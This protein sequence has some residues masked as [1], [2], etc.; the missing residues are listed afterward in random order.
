MT[1]SS[2]PKID[3]LERE[4][5]ELCEQI[6]SGEG[7]AMRLH[8]LATALHAKIA[9]EELRGEWNMH[10]LV[11]EAV[12]SG[13][14]P[15]PTPSLPPP[16]PGPFGS[17]DFT[18]PPSQRPKG[19]RTNPTYPYQFPPT[20]SL[21]RRPLRDENGGEMPE[22]PVS[23]TVGGNVNDDGSIFILMVG[24]G[25]RG[26]LASVLMREDPTKTTRSEYYEEIGRHIVHASVHG[27][28]EPDPAKQQAFE[29]TMPVGATWEPGKKPPTR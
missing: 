21:V 11:T 29:K 14:V 24:R 3:A 1:R 7:N 28:L 16:P 25:A 18:I 17:V 12:Q 6:R 13:A 2:S 26:E 8:A 4:L 5:D 19:E 20:A 15:F 22:H 23:I 27:Y 9:L 10:R